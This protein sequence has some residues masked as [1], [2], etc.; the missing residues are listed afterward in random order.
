MRPAAH[1]IQDAKLQHVA[2][3]QVDLRVLAVFLPE[4]I[5]PAPVE[6]ADAERAEQVLLRILG[7]GAASRVFGQAPGNGDCSRAVVAVGSRCRQHRQVE[8]CLDPVGLFVD[9]GFTPWRGRAVVVA[10]ESSL[11]AGRGRASAAEAGDTLS[12]R[13]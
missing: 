6:A 13:R 8:G 2:R 9:H 4:G 12:E 5:V 10:V 11:P 1:G 3:T 7:Q